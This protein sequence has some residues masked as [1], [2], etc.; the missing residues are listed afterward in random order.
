MA[1]R[2]YYPTAPAPRQPVPLTNAWNA[3][4]RTLAPA[5]YAPPKLC[6]GCQ[7]WRPIDCYDRDGRTR[8]GLKK[9]CKACAR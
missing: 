1:M 5:P 9:K 7:Q 6:A 4:L 2:A 3:H 8:D